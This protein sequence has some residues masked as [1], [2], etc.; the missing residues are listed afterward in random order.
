[1]I[2]ETLLASGKLKSLE[3]HLIIFAGPR[4]GLR[5]IQA[6]SMGLM[7]IFLASGKLQSLE[8][9]FIIILQVFVKR[10]N[11]LLYLKD[12]SLVQVP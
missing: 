12:L 2:I 9:H 7:E 8:F 11:D 6:A 10:R 5:L 1:M 3:C 4:D